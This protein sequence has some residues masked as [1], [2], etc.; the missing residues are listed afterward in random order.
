M[1]DLGFDEANFLRNDILNRAKEF[2]K[3]KNMNKKFI[4][5]ETYIPASGKVVD[6]EEL[7]NLIDASLDMWLTSGRYGDEFEKEFSKFLGVK[8]SSLVNSGSSANLVAVT[9]LNSHKLGD[10][11][12]KPGDEV[13]T[14]AAGFPTTV[15]PIVQNGLVP[16]FVDVELG[17]YN[18]KVEELERAI[19][20][21]TKAVVLAHTLGNSFNL[22][23]VMEFAE[24][25]NLWVIEDNC[26]ALGSKYDGK[27][28]GTFG[29]ISTY[30]FYPAHHITMGEGGAVCTNDL[31]LHNI[32]RSIRDWGRDCICP[33][34][35]DNFCGKRFTQQHGE[36]PMGYDHKY[37][38]SHFGYNLKVTDMQAAIGVSQLKKLPRFIEKRRENYKKLYEGLKELEEYLIL[39]EPTENSEPSWFGF[40][41]TL[42]ENTKH[43]RNSLIKF[44]EERKIGTRLLFAGNIL[45]QPLFTENKVEYRVVG[46]LRNTDIVMNNTFWIGVWP[47]IDDEQ[48]NYILENFKTFYS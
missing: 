42:K 11:R 9:A 1:S 34:G 43:D 25:Y 33:P 5:G 29:H 22:S 16:V 8:Y 31:E 35:K 40:P 24:R 3:I 26:D 14:V 12:L 2:H 7:A 47:G 28:T 18:I 6:E 21:R 27:Y 44:L 4:P 37:V 36:L 46:E 30:S 10:R 45:K 20:S 48:I 19:S 17:T 38:Y 39:P 41:I 23:K 15:A 32:I 13:I